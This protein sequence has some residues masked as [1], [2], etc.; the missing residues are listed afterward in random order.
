M[1]GCPGNIFRGD[2]A[3]NGDANLTHQEVIKHILKPIALAG[4]ARLKR[5]KSRLPIV[6]VEEGRWEATA[7]MVV[8]LRDEPSIADGS[9][10][11]VGSR[12]PPGDLDKIPCMDSNTPWEY[13]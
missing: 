13:S 12:R 7:P 2:I 10:T 9:T 11:Y 8:A 3:D 1:Y 4:D 5:N 6:A